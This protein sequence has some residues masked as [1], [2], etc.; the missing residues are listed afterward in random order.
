MCSLRRLVEPCAKLC[1]KKASRANSKKKPHE[2]DSQ[3]LVPL[4]AK[5][6]FYCRR[7]C[8]KAPLVACDYCPSYFHQDCLDPPLTA[9]PTGLWM[10]PNHPEQ[11]IVSVLQQLVQ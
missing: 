6:C 10:C 1:A 4:P 3:G 11:F 8:K 5:T 9:L 2:L 7:S